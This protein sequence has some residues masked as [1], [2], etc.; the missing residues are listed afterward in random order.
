VH[1]KLIF[2]GRKLRRME[3]VMKLNLMPSET[4]SSIAAVTPSRHRVEIVDENVE[5][6]RLDDRPDLVG[7]SVYTFMAPHAY[8]IADHYRAKGVRVVLGGIHVSSLPEDAMPHADTLIIGEAEAVWPRFLDDLERG[9]PKRVYGP[10][11]PPLERLPPPRK[12]L[13]NRNAYLT[14][15]TIGATRGCPHRC[16]FCFQSAPPKAPYRRRRPRD[17]AA[18]VAA[19]N[20]AY[21]IFI[22]DNLAADHAYVR[23]LCDAL[24]PLGVRWR[25]AANLDLARDE[26]LVR[27]MAE[28]GC[29]SVF[30]GFESINAES[31]DESSKRINRRS[32]YERLIRVFHRHR[33]LIN[34][35]F[36]FGFDHDGPEVFRE[37]MRFA[38]ENRL[39]SL[40]LHVL[41]PFPGTELYRRLETE[42]RLLSRDWAKYDTAHVVFRPKRMS[43]EQLAEGYLRAYREL[44]SW[45]N[46]L[47]RVPWSDPRFALRVLLFNIA[48]RKVPWFWRLAERLGV[49][50][51]AFRLYYRKRHPSMPVCLQSPGQ[52]KVPVRPSGPVPVR[53]PAPSP[54]RRSSRPPS[55]ASAGTSH[56][57]W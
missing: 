29:D 19:E 40:T 6:L 15:A 33:V 3:A 26:A 32:E 44:Y 37:T 1:I 31:L 2:P 30:I 12:D 34:A 36:V 47:R 16:G 8:E 28:S 51:Q 55:P 35:S 10:E 57:S 18:Q 56:R 24:K 4:L 50:R 13:V 41:T 48:L 5:P 46:I 49:L 54:L 39:G 43:A 7:V 9:A 38:A 45:R 21:Y 52:E 22:D 11:F 27:L 20:E 23:E 14:T 17:I 25:C 53:L 42:G